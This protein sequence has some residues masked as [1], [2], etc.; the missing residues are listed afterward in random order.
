M[1]EI[2]RYVTP[3]FR[4]SYPNVFVPRAAKKGGDP[5]YGLSAIWTP[6]KFTDKEKVLWKAIL[7]ALDEEAQTRFK[8]PFKSLPAN[9]KRGLRNGNEKPELEGYGEGTIF[10]SVTS[11]MAPGVIDR[12]KNTISPD[13]GNADEIYPGCY[14]RAT[15]TVYGYDNEGKGLALGLMNLQKV[16]DGTRLDSR[17]NAA[18]DFE[19][20][21]GDGDEDDNLLDQDDGSDP[22]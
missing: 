2:K 17:T 10:A 8:K 9:I 5:K 14:C 20:D 7:K 13:E 4:L 19:D 6:S 21:L 15:V 12:N 1:A 22:F 3:V 18:E 11:K 16:K